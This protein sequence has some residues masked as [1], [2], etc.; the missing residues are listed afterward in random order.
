MAELHFYC[1][2]CGKMLRISEVVWINKSYDEDG[3]ERCDYYICS[4]CGN[5]VDE[6][7]VEPNEG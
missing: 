2:H 3:V 4:Y 1:K 6:V 7:I 5:E